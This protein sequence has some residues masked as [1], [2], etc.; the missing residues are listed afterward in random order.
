M[1]SAERVL[2]VLRTQAQ[3]E[4]AEIAA[5]VAAAAA[6]SAAAER[7]VTTVARSCTALEIEL[8]M[9]VSRQP[10]NSSLIDSMYRLYQVDRQLLRESQLRLATARQ[11]E[12]RLRTAMAGA[13]NR[14]RSLERALDTERRKEDLKQQ[15]R[16]AILADDLWLQHAWSECQ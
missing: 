2:G 6:I 14:E 10:I 4:L 15:A 3:F 1:T 13:R 9:C 12:Q 7:Q 16:D 5:K 11:D 8:R